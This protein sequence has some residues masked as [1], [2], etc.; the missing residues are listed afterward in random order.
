MLHIFSI[1]PHI[2]ASAPFLPSPLRGGKE[3]GG[4]L[5]ARQAVPTPPLLSDPS[6]Y[7]CL[8]RATP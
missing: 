7:S 6:D 5:V 8:A 4:L 1:I 3:G 2:I